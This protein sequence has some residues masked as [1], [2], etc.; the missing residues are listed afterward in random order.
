[1]F[2][3]AVGIQAVGSRGFDSVRSEEKIPDQHEFSAAVRRG[4]LGRI[5][6]GTKVALVGDDYAVPSKRREFGWCREQPTFRHY[7]F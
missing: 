1:M 2:G 4:F 6:S 5:P 7:R 3:I